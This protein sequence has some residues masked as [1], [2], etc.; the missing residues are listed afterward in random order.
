MYRVTSCIA[1][2]LVALVAML[3]LVRL[4]SIMCWLVLVVCVVRCSLQVS[5]F[6]GIDVGYVGVIV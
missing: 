3:I 6:F 1:C 5:R 2:R 4:T